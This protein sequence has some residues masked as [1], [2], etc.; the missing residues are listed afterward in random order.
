M[1]GM[2]TSF[3]VRFTAYITKREF[4]ELQKIALR[5]ETVDY[6]ENKYKRDTTHVL[7]GRHWVALVRRTTEIVNDVERVLFPCE[8]S[9]DEACIEPR[10]DISESDL[11]DSSSYLIMFGT[12]ECIDID[13]QEVRYSITSNDAWLTFKC[14]KESYV[15]LFNIVIDPKYAAELDQFILQLIAKYFR[16]FSDMPSMFRPM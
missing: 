13:L 2:L 1:D 14:V 10:D 3:F 7:I 9:V 5:V 8:P 16:V 6:E 15:A 11:L 4:E 12:S